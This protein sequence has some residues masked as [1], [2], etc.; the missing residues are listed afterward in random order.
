MKNMLTHT[1][2]IC[3]LGPKTSSKEKIEELTD[4]GM[5]VARLNFSHG[6]HEEHARIIRLLKEVRQEKDIPLAIMLDNKGPEVRLGKI[7]DNGFFVKKGQRIFLI[8]DEDHIG[9]KEAV[10]LKPK[11]LFSVLEKG[12]ELLMDDGYISAVVTDIVSASKV[13]IE[14]TNDGFLGS[15]KSVSVSNV[16]VPLPFLTEVDFNDIRF[17]CEQGIDVIAASFVRYAEDILELRKFLNDCGK[18]YLPIIAKIENR[19]G[20]KNFN[21][22]ADVSE[23]IMIARGDLGIEL[24]VV[25]VPRLQK[26][27]ADVSRKKGKICITATQML[28]SMINNPLPTRAEV[29]DIANAIYDGT[30]AVML[31]GETASGNYPIEAV[32]IMKAVIIDTEISLT[33]QDFFDTDVVDFGLPLSPALAALGPSCMRIAKAGQAKAIIVYTTEGVSPV[34]LSKYRPE[35][36]IIAV[37]SKDSVYRGLALCWGVFP[38]LSK[39]SDRAIWRKEACEYALEKGLLNLYDE[40]LVL[41]RSASSE[42]TNT[43]AITAVMDILGKKI[44][45]QLDERA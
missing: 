20:V 14:F 36:P 31:S 4:A 45:Q 44:P 34:F 39:S 22:I 2:I 7:E 9:T 3:T 35:I 28:E 40:I 6:T 11:E 17:G 32:K 5:N 43:V 8:D 38:M 33:H 30:S 18:G 23:G 13:E 19:L 26:M 16:E 25:Q 10:A 42:G 37:T 1:K 29:S 41:S 21:K 24:P 12:A 27:M 15:S